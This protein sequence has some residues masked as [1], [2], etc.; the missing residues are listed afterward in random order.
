[1][2]TS[3]EAQSNVMTRAFRA[4]DKDKNG[5]IDKHEFRYILNKYHIRISDHELNRLMQMYDGVSS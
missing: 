3:T 4:L 1:M 2:P 5:H